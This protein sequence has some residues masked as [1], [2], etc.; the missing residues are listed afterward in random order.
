MPGTFTV[1]YTVIAEFGE[2]QTVFYTVAVRESTLM[3]RQSHCPNLSGNEPVLFSARFLLNSPSSTP[4][5]LQAAWTTR[6]S[7][8]YAAVVALGDFPILDGNVLLLHDVKLLHH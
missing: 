8:P 2:Y 6:K 1:V 3:D 7:Q 5:T 4:D